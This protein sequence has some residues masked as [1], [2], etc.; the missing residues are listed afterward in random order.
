M[1]AVEQAFGEV[2]KLQERSAADFLLNLLSYHKNKNLRLLSAKY[3]KEVASFLKEPDQEKLLGIFRAEELPEFHS[4]LTPILGQIGNVQAFQALFDFITWENNELV[5]EALLRIAKR[6]RQEALKA[7]IPYLD[8]PNYDAVQ[9]CTETFAKLKASSVV[10]L[11]VKKLEDENYCFKGLAVAALIALEAKDH[12][13]LFVSVLKTDEDEDARAWAAEAVAKFGGKSATQPLVEALSKDKAYIVRL[14][15]AYELRCFGGDKVVDAL[16]HV[17]KNDTEWRVGKAALHSLVEIDS[18]K[19][20]NVL[21]AELKQGEIPG[22]RVVVAEQLINFEPERV[23]EH[24]IR[25]LKEDKDGEV[26]STAAWVLGGLAA[27]KAVPALVSAAKNEKEIKVRTEA[28]RALGRIGIKSDEVISVLL[29]ALKDTETGVRQAAIYSLGRV[30]DEKILKELERL[31]GKAEDRDLRFALLNA[32]T[33]LN[34]GKY[35]EKLS[36]TPVTWDA[37]MVAK[38]LTLVQVGQ[39]RWCLPQSFLLPA[40]TAPSHV[41]IF[42][43]LFP[44]APETGSVLKE[45]GRDKYMMALYDWLLEN[46]KRLKWDP[47]KKVYVLTKTDKESDK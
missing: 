29:S 9:G 35:T 18:A 7:L 30:G 20:L 3:L 40:L 10:P 32:L 44:E 33:L 38:G 34:P 23:V 15:A 17:F 37:E 36:G 28:L 27:T 47:K 19:A 6:N 21:L 11:L 45:S 5:V 41:R 22:Y 46:E 4:H 12:L 16:A 42:Q 39:F 25:A 26:R 2:V 8:V 14:C 24:L 13:E 43:A 1:E 31:Y